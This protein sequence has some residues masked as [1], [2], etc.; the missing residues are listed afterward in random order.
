MMSSLLWQYLESAR[1]LLTDEEYKE[2]EALVKD[3]QVGKWCTPPPPPPL[4]H[5]LFHSLPPSFP[6][7]LPLSFPPSLSPLGRTW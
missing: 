4:P 3:F 2:M 7:S 1:A 5:S 6:P